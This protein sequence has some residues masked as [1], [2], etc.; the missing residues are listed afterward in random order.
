[1]TVAQVLRKY[2]G[3]RSLREYSKVLGIS[4]SHL[5][6]VLNGDRNAGNDVTRGFLR[7]F[8]EATTEYINAFTA[9]TQPLPAR[10]PEAAAV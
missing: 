4:L 9:E 3:D 7:A 10:E 1:M 2:Q 8:P 6:A 5:W